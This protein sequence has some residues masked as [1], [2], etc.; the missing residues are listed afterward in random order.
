MH[1][2]EAMSQQ[3]HLS[4]KDASAF[5]YHHLNCSEKHFENTFH[6]VK[7]MFSFPSKLIIYVL[8]KA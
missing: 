8:Y 2:P 4:Q 7:L 1:S 6:K 5:D 3:L